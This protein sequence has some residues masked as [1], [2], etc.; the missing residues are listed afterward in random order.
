MSRPTCPFLRDAERSFSEAT[1]RFEKLVRPLDDHRANWSP[2]P[3]AWS[4]AACIDHL[5][6]SAESYFDGL[7]PALD[8][9]RA[10]GRTGAAP[11]GRGTWGGR[12][13]LGV[14]DPERP[15]FRAVKAPS[16]FRPRT[17]TV[18]FLPTCNAFRAVQSRWHDILQKADGLDLGRI[19]LATPV[20]PLL[21]VSA[22]QAILIHTYHEPRHL[23]QAERLIAHPDFPGDP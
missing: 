23:A 16:V 14:L 8:S 6:V 18:E 15:S 10:A 2:D 13:L 4:V 17:E 9:G 11:Y 7:E 22:A 1:E 3:K 21:R 20:S 5:V 19:K 12:L